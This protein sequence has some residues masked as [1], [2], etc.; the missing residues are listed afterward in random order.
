MKKLF[1]LTVLAAF[2]VVPVMAQEGKKET[3]KQEKK[4][5]KKDK[6]Q[7]KKEWKKDI[8]EDKK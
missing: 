1:A 6:M 4:E 2:F 3:P 5:W 8:K 7:D